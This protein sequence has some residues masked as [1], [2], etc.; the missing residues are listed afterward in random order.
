MAQGNGGKR[1]STLTLGDSTY[2]THA[3]R[4]EAETTPA[5]QTSTALALSLVPALPVVD[6]LPV[7][8]QTLNLTK[9][10][11]VIKLTRMDDVTYSHTGMNDSKY[12]PRDVEVDM[13]QEIPNA[14]YTTQT[15]DD[16]EPMP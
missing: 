5:R 16:T 10:N 15:T 13:L 3:A 4:H 14:T 9:D 11:T 7:T 8:E 6:P 12:R 1:I 2:K